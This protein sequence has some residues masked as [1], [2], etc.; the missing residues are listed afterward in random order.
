MQHASMFQ[1]QW[2]APQRVEPGFERF[3]LEARMTYRAGPT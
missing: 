2:G 3:Y 1:E